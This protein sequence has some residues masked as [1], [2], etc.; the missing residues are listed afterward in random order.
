MSDGFCKRASNSSMGL[1]NARWY[2]PGHFFW[3]ER[4][5]TL[6]DQVLMPIQDHVEMGLTLDTL[7][8]RVQNASYYPDLFNDAFGSP[9][10]ERRIRAHLRSL[11]APW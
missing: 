11:C 8:A 3:D 1:A 10:N 2:N 6:E 7:I 9:A 5:A 4:A